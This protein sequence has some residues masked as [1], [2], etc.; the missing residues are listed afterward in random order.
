MIA[1]GDGL[2]KTEEIAKHQE[3]LSSKKSQQR[4]YFGFHSLERWGCTDFMSEKR[5]QADCFC[6]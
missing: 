2:K 4:F 5:K 1:T 6:W 3:G